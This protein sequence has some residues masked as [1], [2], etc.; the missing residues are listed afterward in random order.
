MSQVSIKLKAQRTFSWNGA[1]LRPH[2]KV[3]H[4]TSSD[5]GNGVPL[6]A[7]DCNWHGWLWLACILVKLPKE[8]SVCPFVRRHLPTES[9]ASGC[10][11]LS[12]NI[13]TNHAASRLKSHTRYL[14]IVREPVVRHV[15]ATSATSWFLLFSQWFPH[16]NF[17]KGPIFAACSR[18]AFSQES[19]AGSKQGSRCNYPGRVANA[20]I[21]P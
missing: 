13:Y 12:K 3:S 2:L 6:D 18:A 19:M 10:L 20:Y 11:L 1:V 16:T 15:L 8:I 4:L 5:T 21:D 14:F 17:I 7:T 9:P